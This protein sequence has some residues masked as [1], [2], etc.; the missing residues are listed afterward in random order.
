VASKNIYTADRRIYLDKNGKAVEADDP[1]RVSLLVAAG[2][3]LPMADAERYGLTAPAPAPAPAV[4][5]EPEQKAAAP[6]AN[7]AKGAAPENKG[8]E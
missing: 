3:T 1:N 4:A 7:K 6:K 2:A 5:G 8:Q